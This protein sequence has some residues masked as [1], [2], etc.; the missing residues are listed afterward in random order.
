MQPFVRGKAFESMSDKEYHFVLETLPQL[1]RE[2][3]RLMDVFHQ[4]FPTDERAMSRYPDLSGN[5]AAG[6]VMRQWMNLF[7]TPGE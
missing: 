2:I 6:Y 4:S 7:V 1:R 3:L 5:R